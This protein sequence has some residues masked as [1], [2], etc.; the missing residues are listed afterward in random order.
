MRTIGI[1]IGGTKTEYI[2]IDFS[3]FRIIDRQRFKTPKTRKAFLNL[4]TRIIKL[5]INEYNI[6]AIGIS[7]PGYNDNGILRNTINNPYLEGFNINQYLKKYG[8]PFIAM[9]DADL[10]TY[11]EALM[12]NGK[13]YSIVLGVIWGTGIGGGIVINKKI[14]TG[15]LGA[16]EI[17]HTIINVNG[18]KCRCGKK[19][20]LEAYSGGYSIVKHF[21]E[22]GGSKKIKTVKEI[23]E[24]NS[25]ISRK[26]MREAMKYMQIG[27]SNIINVLSPEI[28]IFGG[29]LSNVS[30]LI[31]HVDQGIDKY[32]NVPKPVIK[33]NLLGDSAG[34][35]GAALMAKEELQKI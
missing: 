19:G 21:H 4:L 2:V 25:Q 30:S 8:K 34:V 5:S 28:V 35:I 29:G 22:L 13:N 14:Y 6:K 27:L 20:C 16:G 11:A 31:R 3:P 12:G 32:L 15:K 10:F 26:V 18:R 9:N 33:T 1:D 24:L 7:H 23:L 17:G